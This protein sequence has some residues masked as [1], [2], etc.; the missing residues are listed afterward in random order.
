MSRATFYLKLA[1]LGVSEKTP[2]GPETM[3]SGRVASNEL[4]VSFNSTVRL[5]IPVTPWLKNV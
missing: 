4:I 1:L 2:N 5:A 3:L